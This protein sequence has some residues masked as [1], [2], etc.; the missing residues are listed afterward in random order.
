MRILKIL[1]LSLAVIFVFSACNKDVDGDG[2]ENAEKSNC[3]N[4][5]DDIAKRCDCDDSDPDIGYMPVCDIDYS[6]CDEE[7][8]LEPGLYSFSFKFDV[9]TKTVNPEERTYLVYVPENYNPTVKTPIVI[10]LHGLNQDACQQMVDSKMNEVAN[11]AENNFIAVYPNAADNWNISGSSNK[12]NDVQFLRYLV[13]DLCQNL[14]VD[15]SMVYVTGMSKG[16]YMANMV[17]CEASGTFAAVAP[18]AGALE[19]DPVECNLRRPVPIH[20]YV[21]DADTDTWGINI[22]LK[23]QESFVQWQIRNGCE[24]EQPTTSYYPDDPDGPSYCETYSECTNDSEVTLCTLVGMGHCWPGGPCTP[25]DYP[26]PCDPETEP[27]PCDPETELCN[28]DINA[29]TDMWNFFK[30]YSLSNPGPFE[31]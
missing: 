27:D 29:S 5:Y 6:M 26:D 19:R 12:A 22:Y 1:A 17:A 4:T 25:G 23:A 20:T 24:D 2:W 16:A 9:S 3:R 13:T 14:C 21:G 8:A 7:D 28:D 10:S 30:D 31:F 11:V 15:R 18:V